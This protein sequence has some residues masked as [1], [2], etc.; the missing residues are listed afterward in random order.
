MHE[1][2]S[3]PMENAANVCEPQAEIDAETVSL[4]RVL[5]TVFLPF[6]CE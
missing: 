1:E 2:V 3:E 4:F 5:T 6:K